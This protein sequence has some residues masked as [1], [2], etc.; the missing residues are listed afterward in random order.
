M[1]SLNRIHLQTNVNI[2]HQHSSLMGIKK[3]GYEEIM[4][5]KGGDSL[6]QFFHQYE[7]GVSYATNTTNSTTGCYIA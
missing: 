6:I 3:Y 5:I 2:L 4:F 7:K 1:G